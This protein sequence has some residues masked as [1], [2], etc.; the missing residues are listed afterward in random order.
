MTNDLRKFDLNLLIVFEAVFTTGNISK[1]ARQLNQ[2]QPTLSNS[3][4]RLRGLVDD[5][6]FVRKGKGVEP[7]TK[8]ISMI[9]PVRDALQIIRTGVA[10]SMEFEPSLS[11][12]TFRIL[13]LDQLEPILIPPVVRQIQDHQSVSL[14]AVPLATTP[15]VESLNNG[16]L[17][18]AL[19]VFTNDLDEFECEVVGCADLVV[20]A[21]KDHPKINGPFTIEHLREISH[22]ALIP[23]MRALSR[24]DE[25]LQRLNIERHIAYT[26]TKMWSFPYIVANTDLIALFPGD[27]ARAA[28]RH[29]PI[30]LQPVPF[31][32]PEQQIYMIW[33]KNL[34]DDPGHRWLRNQIKS[35]YR[36]SLMEL[37]AADPALMTT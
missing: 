9:G 32:V 24:V 35:A 28:A 3:L 19:S 1:A 6:L 27:F 31:E 23:Q 15:V 14:E 13:I 18:L 12:R 22:I 26:V 17:D 34:T 7:T 37:E 20:I 36:Q 33:K 2:S 10:G 25:A 21:R 16:T 5:P 29:F 4:T 8:A 11:K 30:E